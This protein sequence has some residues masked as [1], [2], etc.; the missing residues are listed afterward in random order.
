MSFAKKVLKTGLFVGGALG[1]L[2]LYNRVTE[3]MAGELDTVLT[4]E[5]RCY[6]W[7]YGDM[8]YTVKGNASATPLLLLHSPEPGASSFIWRKNIDALADDFCVY[9]PDLLGFGMS[10]RMS[11]DYDGELYADLISDFLQEAVERPA[12]V[13][14]HGLSCA[15][16]IAV[17]YRRPQLFERLI[18]V[19][20]PPSILHEVNPTP[21]HA[22]GRT[23]LTLPVV[24]QFL[25]NLL[26]SRP[27]IRAYYDRQ[28]YHDPGLITD[29]LVE[30]IYTSAHQSNS[31][32]AVA[33]LLTGYLHLDV[34]DPLSRLEVPAVAL[35]GRE[36]ALL[37]AEVRAIF[38]HVN[39]NLEVG[40]VEKA[41]NHIQEEQAGQF[42]TLLRTFALQPSQS[43]RQS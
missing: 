9:A 38:T 11:I 39:P 25:Y 32:Y 12:V 30:Y 28:G 5:E 20:P 8:F 4:G 22:L 33:S 43:L 26:T 31:Q 36:G 37:P 15:Y 7:K 18:L 23:I 14:A 27:A 17:A 16:A 2:A 29:E 10:D 35:W 13:V 21:L 24:G 42:N 6:P 41:M 3:S 19:A 40:I 1:A 34:Q